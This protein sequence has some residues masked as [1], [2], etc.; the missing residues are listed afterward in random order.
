M[1]KNIRCIY[2]YYILN[3]L[4]RVIKICVKYVILKMIYK[5]VSLLPNLLNYF[6]CSEHGLSGAV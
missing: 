4:R 2:V 5:Y 1:I 3:I 6:V